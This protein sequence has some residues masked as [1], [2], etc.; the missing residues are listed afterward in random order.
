MFRLPGPACWFIL[1]LVQTQ[2]RHI[3][4]PKGV[5]GLAALP[6]GVTPQRCRPKKSAHPSADNQAFLIQNFHVNVVLF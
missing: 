3:V 1:K 2:R 5:M 4:P 6:G